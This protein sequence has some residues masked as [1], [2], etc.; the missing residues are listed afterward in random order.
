M[1]AFLFFLLALICFVLAALRVGD[2]SRVNITA[3]GLAF[4]VI[5]FLAQSWPA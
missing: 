1:L 5:P 4:A 3:A 2:S